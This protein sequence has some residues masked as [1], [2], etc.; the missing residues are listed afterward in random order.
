MCP[1]RAHGAAVRAVRMVT[2]L[3]KHLSLRPALKLARER[4]G[5]LQLERSQLDNMY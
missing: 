4:A 1:A 5:L 2:F 3:K